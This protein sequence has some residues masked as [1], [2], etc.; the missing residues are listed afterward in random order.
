MQSNDIFSLSLGLASSWKLV[1]QQLNT[2]KS[3]RELHLYIGADRG[4]LY[5]CPEC[6]KFCM[7]QDFKEMTWRHLNFFQHHCYIT[8]LVPRTNCPEHGPKRI[9]VPWAREGNHFTQLFEQV[10]MTMLRE[11]PVLVGSPVV[12]LQMA[13]LRD[14]LFSPS[15]RVN[16]MQSNDIFALGLG[17]N[18]PWNLM[19]Q[20]LDMLKKPRELHLHIGADRGALYP[21][22]EC[23]K[24]CKAHDF[25][26]MTWRYLNF[27]QHHCYI[28][29]PVPRTSCPEHGIM[30][31]SLPWVREGQ[32]RRPAL[33]A[34]DHYHATRNAD[35]RPL[36]AQGCN[37]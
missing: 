4:V 28:T 36:P 8:A 27:F 1:G 3:P 32:P 16:P 10:A 33:R 34:G 17:L 25:K 11:M 35:S 2:L 7:A 29:A 21:C 26:E 20:Q 9:N 37:G 12:G 15:L 18:A 13:V 14:I 24:F 23:G 5:P 19:E 22:P 6:G 31:I 30:R